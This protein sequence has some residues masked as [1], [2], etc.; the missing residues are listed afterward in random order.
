METALFGSR[1]EMERKIS[2][3]S[4]GAKINV[5]DTINNLTPETE[6]V[7]LLYHINFGFP[8]FYRRTQSGVSGGGSPRTYGFSSKK[9]KQP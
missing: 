1:L 8:F 3:P 7:F 4:D 6:T 2:I 5:C 9:Y